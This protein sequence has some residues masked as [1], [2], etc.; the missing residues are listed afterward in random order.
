MG[1][2]TVDD[3]SAPFATKDLGEPG[4]TKGPWAVTG[5]RS[6]HGLSIEAPAAEGAGPG[7]RLALLP[8]PAPGEAEARANAVLVAS[9]PALA[10]AIRRYLE[11]LEK[12]LEERTLW[13]K[14]AHEAAEARGKRITQAVA[15]HVAERVEA[16]RALRAAAPL[17]AALALAYGK[18]PQTL[19]GRE[20]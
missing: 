16:Q 1:R 8:S 10:E 20:S 12:R 18:D 2:L 13:L 9:S 4:W 3:K 7:P 6:A 19:G 17:C 11:D 15:V 14:K 5:D